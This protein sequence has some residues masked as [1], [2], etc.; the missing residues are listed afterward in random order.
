MYVNKSC[1]LFIIITFGVWIWVS[2][3]MITVPVTRGMHTNVHGWTRAHVQRERWEASVLDRY[4]DRSILEQVSYKQSE[5]R[6]SNN[7]GANSNCWWGVAPRGL[8]TKHMFEPTLI[9]VS[10]DEQ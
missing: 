1:R 4:R 2:M 3:P 9:L 6:A 5:C 8:F 10:G 7:L